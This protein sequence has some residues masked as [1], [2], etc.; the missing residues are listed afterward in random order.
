[1][2]SNLPA[3][4]G[5]YDIDPIAV[6]QVMAKSGFFADTRDAAQ[7]A[8]KVMWGQ[9]L[10]IGPVTA[11]MGIHIIKGKLSMSANLMGAQIR[12]SGRYTF[13]VREL[14]HES[15]A[16]EFFEG[17]DSLGVSSYSKADAQTA[18]LWGQ[19]G[20]W[21][22]HPRNMLYARAMSNGAKWFCPDAF[23]GSPVYTPD[24]LG[25]Q[26]DGETGEVIEL[27]PVD[28][29]PPADPAMQVARERYK[30]LADEF[31]REALDEALVSCGFTGPDLADDDTEL[32]VSRVLET[33][34]AL[35]ADA[36][37]RAAESGEVIS[38]K[39][40]R[41]L[42]A[43]AKEHGM[44]HDG[45]KDMALEL[46]GVESTTLIPAGQVQALRDTIVKRAAKQEA[47]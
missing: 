3:V 23:G 29:R 30:R 15:V 41:G 28:A 35:A 11:M 32:R 13:R 2:G 46:F 14:E 36:A 34:Q 38:E 39:D 24:E 6:G 21:K 44:D 4:R 45:L 37:D 26:V 25:A 33:R 17:A 40:R 18:G 22:Q 31:G 19:A 47:A 5:G 12:R 42:E 27:P 20:P 7:A 1:M 43:H 9:E 16:I 8:V 10:G